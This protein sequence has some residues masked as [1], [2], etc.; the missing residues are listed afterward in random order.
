[1]VVGLRILVR[2]PVAMGFLL[3]KPIIGSAYH[4][5]RPRDL[6]RLVRRCPLASAF[7][8]GDS[9][10]LCYSLLEPCTHE[11]RPSARCTSTLTVSRAE[12]ARRISP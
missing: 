8:N 3:P 2:S 11:A 6:G 10:S 5:F 1:M 4:G 7:S 9:Y 12:M